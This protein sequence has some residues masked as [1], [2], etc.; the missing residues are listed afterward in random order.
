MNLSSISR[1]A[2]SLATKSTHA[3]Y[4]MAAIL[5]KSGHPIGFGVNKYTT[6]HYPRTRHAEESALLSVGDGAHGTT[7]LVVR[8]RRNG[9]LGMARPCGRCR[10]TLAAAGVKRA[11]YSTP[12]G[13]EVERL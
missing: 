12:V 3:R 7:V 8:V 10:L 4:P 9:T 6:S 1:A 11:V 5:L 2:V 13:F